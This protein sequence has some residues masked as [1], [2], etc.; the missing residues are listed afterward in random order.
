MKMVFGKFIESSQNR[1]S[2]TNTKMEQHGHR[3]IKISFSKNEL[4][5]T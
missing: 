1:E 3:G 5:K 2:Q 4:S